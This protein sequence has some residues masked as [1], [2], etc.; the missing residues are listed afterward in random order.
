MEKFC[1]NCNK[2]LGKGQTKY[3]SNACQQEYQ[4]KQ[5]IKKWKNGE[6]P[7][8]SGTNISPYVR[9]YMLEKNN[10]SCELCGWNKINPYS[11]NSPLQIHHKDGNY[12]NNTEENLQVLCPN[13]H[14]LTDTYKNMNKDSVRDRTQYIGRKKIVNK[15]IDCGKQIL[16]ESIRCKECQAKRRV[17]PLEDMPITREELKELIYT[18]P[19]TTIG[20]RFGV[21]DNAIRKWC[22][23]YDLPSKKREIKQYNKEEWEKI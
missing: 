9:K 14:S 8:Y 10:Y 7:G 21:T 11:G 13:C 20:K 3:C 18:L 23:Q 6:L 17:I 2:P 12:T 1:L 5:R 15:C 22:I 4:F 19:F 16:S